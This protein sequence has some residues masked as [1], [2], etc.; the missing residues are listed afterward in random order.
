MREHGCADDGRD[1]PEQHLHQPKV[2]A[3]SPRRLFACSVA[4]STDAGLSADMTTIV[5]GSPGNPEVTPPTEPGQSC[6]DGLTP[7]LQMPMAA[8]RESKCAAP[9]ASSLEIKRKRLRRLRLWV[10]PSAEP[11]PSPLDLEIHGLGDSKI[12]PAAGPDEV[13]EGDFPR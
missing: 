9:F 10:R 3:P 2:S 12:R 13:A 6:A 8:C 5:A 4:W 7:S 1:H 11:E